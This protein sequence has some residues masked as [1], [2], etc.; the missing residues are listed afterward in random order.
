MVT[1]N[2]NYVYDR[3]L[4]SSALPNQLEASKMGGCDKVI[5]YSHLQFSSL[6]HTGV[7]KQYFSLLK[8]LAK[9]SSS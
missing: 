1:K 6:A 7:G 2:A 9:K 3:T 5:R 4:S 8:F